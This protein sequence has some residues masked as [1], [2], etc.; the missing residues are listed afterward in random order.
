MSN[1]Q[2]NTPRNR[3]NT[4][5]VRGI[6]EVLH[7]EHT[8]VDLLL[9]GGLDA[10]D[11]LHQVANGLAHLQEALLAP[12]FGLVGVETPSSTLLEDIA[13]DTRLAHTLRVDQLRR[14]EVG[15]VDVADALDL[16][17][18]GTAA[19]AASRGDAAINTSPFAYLNDVKPEPQRTPVIFSPVRKL[20]LILATHSHLYNTP[21]N[22]A[23]GRIRFS[24]R[25]ARSNASASF[26]MPG[27]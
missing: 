1:A 14:V 7:G 8:L 18:D 15:C 5:V 11:L 9:G 19:H 22:G 3:L 17:S 4:V 24:S 25:S 2:T 16:R 12:P 23:I 13:G 10:V 27:L 6:V 26:V 20:P 21:R